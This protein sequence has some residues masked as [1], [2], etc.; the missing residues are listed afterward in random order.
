MDS[1][2]VINFIKLKWRAIIILLVALIIAA[3]VVRIFVLPT[4]ISSSSGAVTYYTNVS[5]DT[6]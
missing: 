1:T 4:E 6:I 5:L 3:I 2:Q